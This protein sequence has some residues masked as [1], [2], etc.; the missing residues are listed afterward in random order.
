VQPSVEDFPGAFSWPDKYVR[1]TVIL[2]AVLF[3]VAVGQRFKVRRVRLAVLGV[4]GVF[5]AYSVVLIAIYPRA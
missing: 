2:A 1:L 4:A 5:L 3:L